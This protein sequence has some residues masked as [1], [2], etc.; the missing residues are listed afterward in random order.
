MYLLTD[1][2]RNYLQWQANKNLQELPSL[3]KTHGIEP[4]LELGVASDVF[5]DHVH[6]LVG[7]H[8]ESIQSV[9]DT[10]ER[11]KQRNK[12]KKRTTR[13]ISEMEERGRN[14]RKKTE[15]ISNQSK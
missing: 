3:R 6:L 5:T 4:T 8:E 2:N 14:V 13:K 1:A 7:V 15:A 12:N 9:L 10:Q 11:K